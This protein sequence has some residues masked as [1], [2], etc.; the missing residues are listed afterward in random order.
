MS[1]LYRIVTDGYS[2]YEVQYRT[3]WWPFWRQC[4]GRLGSVNTH[5]SIEDAE[6]Y[7]KK[8]AQRYAP[9]QIVRVLGAL[10]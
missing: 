8:D 7:A 3:N 4:P 10:P 9:Q 1:R 6:A 2:G 5:P